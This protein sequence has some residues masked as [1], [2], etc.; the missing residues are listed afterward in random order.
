M[1]A[2]VAIV[3]RPNVGKSTLFNKIVGRRVSIVK[4]VKGVTRD[5]IYSD[6]EWCGHNFM[7]IDTGG[8]EIKSQ[9]EMYQ[10]MLRQARLAVDMADVIIFVVDGL[11]GLVS[12]DIEVA[13]FLRKSGKKVIVAVNK[14]DTY[15]VNK[16]Y[17]FYKLDLG[18][19]I[20]ISSEQSK[21]IGDLL[22]VVVSNFTKKESDITDTLK[23]AVVGRPN[24]GKSS[25]VN[26]ILGYERVIVTNIAGTTRDAI[27]TPFDYNNKKYTIIDTA[28]MRRKRSIDDDTI[29]S[30][31]VMR[32][33]AAIKRAD[34]VLVV[35]DASD[36]I[37]EQDVRIA[38]L[39]HEEGKPNIIVFNKWDIVEKDTHTINK[40]NKNL[41]AQLDFMSYFVPVYVS[42]LTG[43]RIPQL[44]QTVDTV[45]ANA[46]R[47][48]NVG[49][50]NEI[51]GQAAALNTPVAPRGQR[52]KINFT[53]QSGTN[54]PTFIIFATNAQLVH[55]TYKRYIENTIRKAIDFSGVP[56][57]IFFDEKSEKQ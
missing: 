42:A 16:I 49:Q 50:L 48:V 56:I 14:L 30:Y 57:R 33:I 10:Q 32:S 26:K 27:D 44:L 38:G 17:D 31:S 28:G 1:S 5:R 23:I 7:L 2:I 9:D 45:Q 13:H 18:D 12:D 43:L 55:N 34:I 6:S 52:I 22:D 51:I 40:F 19:P 11:D 46:S 4:N 36:G 15:D 20:G 35:F 54:P 3:G 29:E 21:G 25:I 39:V 8:L 24:V 53:T 37:T 47:Q 41:S